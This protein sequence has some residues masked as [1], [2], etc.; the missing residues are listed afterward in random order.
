DEGRRGPDGRADLGR[1]EKVP[2][3]RLSEAR[4]PLVRGALPSDAGRGPRVQPPRRI[5]LHRRVLL[6]GCSPPRALLPGDG[7]SPPRPHPADR[8]QSSSSVPR[9]SVTSLSRA[10]GAPSSGHPSPTHLATCSH[11]TLSSSFSTT[12]LRW[13]LGH[14][15]SFGPHSLR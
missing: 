5:L 10:V 15:A 8:P 12:R 1:P 9:R 13:S 6:R 3:G 2:P 11:A 7:G 4:L 14:S